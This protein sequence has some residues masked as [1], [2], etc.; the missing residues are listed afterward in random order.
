MTK[1]HLIARLRKLLELANRG[2][3]GE[4]TNAEA[5]LASLMAK[6]GISHDELVAKV[7][8]LYGFVVA[9]RHEW[10][11]HQCIYLMS[12][13]KK[14]CAI[15]D[16]PSHL[17]PWR[18]TFGATTDATHVALLTT[19][20]YFALVTALEVYSAHYDKELEVFQ[21]AFCLTNALTVPSPTESDEV[22][23]I[24][25]DALRAYEM[26]AHVKRT[27]VHQRLAESKS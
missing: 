7:Y 27:H 22:D 13:R 4:A 8:E 6:Y 19:A 15:S 17:L 11:F 23:L 16:I 5:L 26:S 24:S 2:V 10:L 20:E 25:V 21:T 3:D 1:D 18:P 14:G 9:D 12:K